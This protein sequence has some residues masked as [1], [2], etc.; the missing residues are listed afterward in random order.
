[1]GLTPSAYFRNDVTKVL[2]RFAPLCASPS[3]KPACGITAQA[4][5]CRPLPDGIELDQLSRP[6]ERVPGEI[7]AEMLPRETTALAPAIQPLEEQA[8]DR[9][10]KAGEGAT[11]VGHPKV[12]EVPTHFTPHRVPEV[13]ECARIALLAEPAIEL[14]QGASQ[15]LLQG[16]IKNRPEKCDKTEEN[17]NENIL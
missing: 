7:P 6:W 16:T 15:T 3:Q 9:P 10:L 12:V 13:G 5:S 2:A 1:M 11:I 8:V 14:H 17:T 4:S